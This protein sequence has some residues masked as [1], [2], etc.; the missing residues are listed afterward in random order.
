MVIST[1]T[2]AL[3]KAVISFM[4]QKVL[5]AAVIATLT[6]QRGVENG[7]LIQSISFSVFLFSI[8]ICVILFFLLKTGRTSAFYERIF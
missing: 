7:A 3:D 6:L 1:E 4:I 2:S 8:V 5:G